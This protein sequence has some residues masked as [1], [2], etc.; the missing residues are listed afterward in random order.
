MF[1]FPIATKVLINPL[2]KLG[3]TDGTYTRRYSKSYRFNVP[4]DTIADV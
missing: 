2:S 3:L 4:F 1:Q